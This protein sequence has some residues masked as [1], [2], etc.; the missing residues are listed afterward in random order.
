MSHEKLLVGL[1]L[2]A[3]AGCS[4]APKNPTGS[5]SE[6]DRVIARIVIA[7]HVLIG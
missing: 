1:S 4:S 2:L 3:L 7:H 6:P 5:E